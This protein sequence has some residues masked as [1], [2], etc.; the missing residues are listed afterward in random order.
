MFYFADID[1]RFLIHNKDIVGFEDSCLVLCEQMIE[2]VLKGLL[3]ENTGEY[4]NKNNL[5]LL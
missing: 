1:Y 2:K 4:P 3:R 5:K